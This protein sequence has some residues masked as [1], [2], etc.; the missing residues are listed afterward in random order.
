MCR[1][2]LCFSIA[3]L[4]LIFKET[5]MKQTIRNHPNT[6]TSGVLDPNFRYTPSYATD[7]MQVFKQMGW[8]PPS[9]K[10]QMTYEQYDIETNPPF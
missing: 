9:E 10:K 3:A 2:V 6:K 1:G 8:V 4:I 5:D 7:I